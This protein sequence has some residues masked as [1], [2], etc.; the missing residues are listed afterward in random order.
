MNVLVTSISAKV[1][2]LKTVKRALSKLDEGGRLFGADLDRHC[3]GSY[4]VDRF[5]NMPPI[6][7]LTVEE[8]VRF[9]RMNGIRA[10]I[11]SRDGELSFFSAN[12]EALREEDIHVM[13]S[14]KACVEVCIDKVRFAS[15]LLE[16]AFPVIPASERLDFEADRYVVKERYGAGGA[17]AGL[18]LDA[19]EAVRHAGRLTH[20][21]FQPYIEGTEVSVDV[22][23]DARGRTKG[24]IPRRRIRVVNGESQLTSTFRDEELERMCAEMAERLGAYG[25]ILFQLIQDGRGRWHVLECN[26]RFGGASTLSVAAGLDSF[27]W[28]LLECSGVDL[29]EVPFMRSD[30]ELTL[31]RHAEDRIQ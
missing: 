1:P 10:V 14:D 8:L 15:R 23:V 27:C 5:W 2:M 7:R 25:H 4:F 29:A 13:V 17:G 22:Y 20:P 16:N 9:C 19:E 6:D 11:P 30:R 12:R 18:A 21:V 28:F 24:V 31:I 3:I 26:T